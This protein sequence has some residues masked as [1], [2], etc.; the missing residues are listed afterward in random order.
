MGNN[1]TKNKSNKKNK[2]NKNNDLNNIIKKN[3]ADRCK[4]KN[5]LK[6]FI[7]DNNQIPI[8][9]RLN[10]LFGK[11]F[12]CNKCLSLLLLK[13]KDSKNERGELLIEGKCSNNHI[14][15]KTIKEILK[16][17]G[18]I[19]FIDKFKIVD[20]F[21]NNRKE[22]FSNKHSFYAFSMYNDPAS[23][24]NYN[25]KYLIDEEEN[26]YY[27]F[28]L[29]KNKSDKKEFFYI[30]NECKIIYYDEVEDF[31]HEHPTYKFN[32]KG[33]I[34]DG[35]STIYNLELKSRK[36][37]ENKINSQ[38]S[39][40]E[41][42]KNIITKNDLKAAKQYLDI[43][44]DEIS[45][46]KE[47]NNNYI[48]KKS[49][50]NYDNYIS[51]INNIKLTKFDVEKY[52][53]CL[54]KELIL[55]ITELNNQ[56]ENDENIKYQNSGPAS[57]SNYKSITI[58]EEIYDVCILN[59]DYFI[60]TFYKELLKVYKKEFSIKENKLNLV[61]IFTTESKAIKIVKLNDNRIA[62]TNH[63]Y[64]S[65]IYIYSFSNNYTSYNLEKEIL[66]TDMKNFEM[67]KFKHF[68]VLND[69][70]KI[71]FYKEINKN[72]FQQ[73]ISIF[74]NDS[75]HNIH[76]IL[77]INES[78]FLFIQNYQLFFYSQI[79]FNKVYESNNRTISKAFLLKNNLLGIIK[80]D[81]L[82]FELELDIMNI[83]TKE[84]IFHLNEKCD[85]ILLI[86]GLIKVEQMISLNEDN[87]LIT[88]QIRNGAGGRFY[89]MTEFVEY[90]K[91]DDNNYIKG[92]Q[93]DVDRYSPIKMNFIDNC[94]FYFTDYSFKFFYPEFNN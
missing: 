64:E 20:N 86:M 46:I 4:K 23:R 51:I 68:L 29:Y 1:N 91:T 63:R 88:K 53:N 93:I 32:Y 78:L 73:I 19:K 44:S 55:K 79:K 57:L 18:L 82:D 13:I 3:D 27:S 36:K 15:I 71:K 59:K 35:K 28:S 77:E 62:G 74:F 25:I 72:E 41:N 5:Y 26:Y 21:H 87:F 37:F 89:Y 65:I 76:N 10:N 30:C 85:L 7:N 11:G 75:T 92:N 70:K 90:I 38:I 50:N 40:Y 24:L 22:C 14:A 34:Y 43:I 39:Y 66:I 81:K 94:F 54:D 47:I 84:I 45:L 80:N 56:L 83:K 17:K 61:N 12:R 49:K 9:D 42:L 33:N 69:D 6:D 60:V 2:N 58:E 31:I 52:E 8:I 16:T 48:E 67:N